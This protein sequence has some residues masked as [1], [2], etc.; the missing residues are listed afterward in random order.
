MQDLLNHSTDIIY[1]DAKEV[2][3]Q[4]IIVSKIVNYMVRKELINENYVP[5][6]Q[7]GL[8][9]RLLTLVFLF[10]VVS[11]GL[12]LS[13]PITTL[14][15]LYS[16]FSIRSVAG[17]YHAKTTYGCFC[18][19]IILEYFF[20]GIIYPSLT[21]FISIFIFSLST[22]ILLKLAPYNHPNIHLSQAELFACA[23]SLH[24][25]S[26]FIVSIFIVACILKMK[27]IVYGITIGIAMAAYLLCLAYISNWRLIWKERRQF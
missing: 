3:Y 7:Y 17:G 22:I 24:H 16:F 12:F 10:P 27:G 19:S 1:I 4:V 13:T 9:R 23:E 6:L 25:R 2:T 18:M 5:W 15:F 21:F 8:E 26:R 20:L 14:S 11:L